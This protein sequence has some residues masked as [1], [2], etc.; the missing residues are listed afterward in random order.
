MTTKNEVEK[1]DITG[2]D[3]AAN[4]KEAEYDLV[5]ALLESADKTADENI[6]EVAVRR[7]GKFMFAVHM[8]PISEPDVRMARKKA[9]VYMPNPNNKKLPPIEKDFDTA[10]F[11]SWL[12]YL[13]TTEEDQQKVWGN[14]TIMQKFGLAM[15]VESID[16]L[17][18]MGEKRKLADLVT[19]ISGMDDDDE[20]VT[21]EEF[22]D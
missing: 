8:H 17:L 22:R 18:T 2:L 1:K 16:I 9:T 20:E 4:R 12:I 13:S 10:K 21:E 7:A 15:P 11:N 5:K 14:P 19:E 6:T 3:Q